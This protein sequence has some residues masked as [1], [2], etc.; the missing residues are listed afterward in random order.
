MKQVRLLLAKVTSIMIIMSNVLVPSRVCVSVC[1][2]MC[3]ECSINFKK[4]DRE[5][6]IQTESP[7]YKLIH[8]DLDDAPKSRP[9]PK[10]PFIEAEPPSEFPRLKPTA[11]RPAMPASQ[12]A[13][14]QPGDHRRPVSKHYSLSWFSLGVPVCPACSHTPFFF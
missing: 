6:V 2:C 3:R 10:L 5:A 12:P 14:N 13:P 1:L 8:G 7:T 11:S 9:P 4:Y